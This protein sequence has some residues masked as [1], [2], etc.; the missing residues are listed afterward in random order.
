L[1]RPGR[2]TALGGKQGELEESE[3]LSGNL[4]GDKN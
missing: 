1:I 4:A 3:K 2:A